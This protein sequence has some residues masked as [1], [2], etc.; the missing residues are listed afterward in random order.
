MTPQAQ[1]QNL[2]KQVK[3]LNKL[4]ISMA[5]HIEKDM[6]EPRAVLLHELMGEFYESQDSIGGGVF[7]RG[8]DF[9]RGDK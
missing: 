5:T 8:M 1:I 9:E 7:E 2:E 3:N 4:V 6:L